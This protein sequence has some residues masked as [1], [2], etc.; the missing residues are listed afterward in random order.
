VLQS[1]SV[2]GR[3]FRRSLLER[4]TERET[5]LESNLWDLEEHEL[6]YQERIVPEEEYSFK[7]AFT[8]ETVYESILS[9]RR[10]EIHHEI[11]EA[12]EL[13]YG[14]NLDEYYEQLAY[15]Y[16]RSRNAEK[17]VEYLLKAGEK[18][19]RLYQNDEAIA[20]FQRVLELLRDSQLMDSHKD[21]Q[22]SA[23]KGI[24]RVY[25]IMGNMPKAE[26]YARDAITLGKEI[27]LSA[28]ELALLY[29]RLAD[30]MRWQDR[31]DERWRIGEEA[32]AILGDDNRSI[33]AALINDHIGVGHQHGKKNDNEKFRKFISRNLQFIQ[34]LPYSSDLINAY[35]D[36]I[37]MY[38]MDKNIEEAAKWAS[39]LERLG[40]EHNDLNALATAHS[41]MGAPI[42]Q[43]MGD[44]N[45]AVA[46]HEKSLEIC[47]K[48]GA[49]VRQCSSLGF[50]G[51]YLIRL[52]NPQKALE[53]GYRALTFAKEIG[54]KFAIVET[55]EI[56][57]ISLTCLH[58][59]EKALE[60]IPEL[61]EAA[62]GITHGS[63]QYGKDVNIIMGWLYLHNGQR[64]KAL[65]MFRETIAYS[66]KA[67]LSG[68]EATCD[69]PDE[70]CSFCNRYRAEH[71]ETAN[72]SM[73]Q[74]Y[75]EPGQASDFSKSI[76]CD[77]FAD[78]LSSD[79]VWHDHFSDCSFTTGNGLEI[80]AANGRDLWDV[81]L[82]APR[83]MRE[84][85]GDFAV[86]TCCMPASEDI[87]AIGGIVLW[88]DKENFLRLDR[89]TRGE[90]EIALEGCINNRN[91]CIGRG[92][93][94]PYTSKVFLRL[95]RIG[96]RIN[97]LCSSD[98]EEWFIVGRVEFPEDDP[99]EIGLH[100]IG[101]IDRRIYHGAYPDGTAIRFESFQLWT[102]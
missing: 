76:V 41:M 95:E 81:N 36:I 78:E 49:K 101:N 87:P 31:H 97:A 69:D 28:R 44:L 9:R 13:L 29:S 79:W 27:D 86:Q 61:C 52:G 40:Q 42:L 34:D 74:W 77:T 21:W 62:Q 23:L 98:G 58:S 35:I 83:V 11:A 89:G 3:L 59:Y 43:A 51:F 80:H 10:A 1:A 55:Y 88:K 45:G 67:S 54:A 96:S 12:M 15:H 72:W 38:W 70:F 5:E 18:S 50:M 71:P 48:M 85:T 39:I 94:T 100:A 30:T 26:S 90:R 33:E 68:I 7:H 60:I 37:R 75:L 2:I 63:L 57:V 20:Y 99:V 22:L 82:S 56:I 16:D 24:S 92:H 53:Y 66:P 65:E 93:L 32:L 8:Q 4:V 17:A 6:I 102:G 91:A 46:S 25:V 73:K 47:T 64:E 84:A 14:A 19:Q